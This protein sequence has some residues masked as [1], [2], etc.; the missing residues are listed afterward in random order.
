MNIFYAICVLKSNFENVT[1]Q[2]VTHSCRVFTRVSPS[3]SMDSFNSDEDAHHHHE[4]HDQLESRDLLGRT[5]NQDESQ[6]Q[7]DA[8]GRMVRSIVQSHA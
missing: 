2:I 4:S 5:Q 3:N 6:N 8:D 7:D 1:V